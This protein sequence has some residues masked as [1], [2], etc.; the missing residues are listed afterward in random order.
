MCCNHHKNLAWQHSCHSRILWQTSPSSSLKC[1][2]GWRQKLESIGKRMHF[3]PS[4]PTASAEALLNLS[5]DNEIKIRISGNVCHFS[6]RNYHPACY[7][8]Q[9][10]LGHIQDERKVPMHLLEVG[11]IQWMYLWLQSLLEVAHTGLG[12]A[13]HVTE[14][15]YVSHIRRMYGTCWTTDRGAHS[16]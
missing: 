3:F 13:L 7:A 16:V 14:V 15:L 10:R 6:L 2:K 1:R 8:K 4:G 9:W 12:G 5:I 11:Y